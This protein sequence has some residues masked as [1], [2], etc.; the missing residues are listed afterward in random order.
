MFHNESRAGDTHFS[1]PE[2]AGDQAIYRSNFAQAGV[3]EKLVIGEK[4]MTHAEVGL[5]R[6]CLRCGSLRVQRSRRRG[7]LEQ[8][9]VPLG[10]AVCRCHDCRTRQ[11]YF[12]SISWQLRD[13]DPETPAWAG[14][15]LY[16]STLGACVWLI[17]WMVR[18]YTGISG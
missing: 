14:V 9:A 5:A 12:G 13:R 1:V 4:P 11:V 10:G 18:N 17:W 3:L 2:A 15:L 6:R 7:P 16:C 8:I